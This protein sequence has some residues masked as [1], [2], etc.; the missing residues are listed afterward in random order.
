MGFVSSGPRWAVD[1]TRGIT[2]RLAIP[3][4][5]L[6]IKGSPQTWR[7]KLEYLTKEGFKFSARYYMRTAAVRL[8]KSSVPAEITSIALL[9]RQELVVRYR[10]AMT[11][12]GK[13]PPTDA[14]VEQV[15]GDIRDA[16]IAREKALHSIGTVPPVKVVFAPNIQSDHHAVRL[17]N[18]I[19]ATDQLPL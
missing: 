13:S 7:V 6:R 2:I 18:A 16:I 14:E 3:R 10:E 8:S 11:N 15:C 4:G 9:D 19:T 1:R 5:Q 17:L 12:A